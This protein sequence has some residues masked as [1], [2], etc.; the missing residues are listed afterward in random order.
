MRHSEE[1]RHR[2]RRCELLRAAGGYWHRRGL[3][4]GPGQVVA[5]P[6]APLLL[7]GLLAT[8][9]PA[10]GG[11][12]LTRPSAPWHEHPVRLLGRT[13]YRIPAPADCGGVPDPFVLLE[14][15]R[16]AR[17]AGDAPRIVLVSVADDPTGTAAAPELLREVCE[18]AWD[19][20]LLVV[21][22]ESGRDA[23]HDPHGTVTVSPAEIVGA[24]RAEHI[25]SVV[26][27]TGLTG[28]TGSAALAGAGGT[29]T[30]YGAPAAALARFPDTSR[31]HTLA[32]EVR[33]VLT[34]LHA[35]L[36]ATAAR[37]ATD[38]LGES[39]E[40]RERRAAD[41]RMQGALATAL[42]D[43]VVAAGGLCLPPQAG[44]SVYADLEPLRRPLAAHGIEDAAELA[45]ELTRRIGPGAVS[46]AHF[47]DAPRLLRVR[48]STL[49]LTGAD[50][51]RA[52]DP[53]RAPH[54]R[55]ALDTLRSVLAD[56]TT[57]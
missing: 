29:P 13:P 17:S 15:V 40:A 46:G 8:A 54:V 32:R 45:A 49:L 53:L 44:R 48:L 20:G 24:E 47:G 7:L 27:L 57:G 10:G 36:P 14:T 6:S 1:D 19:E 11:V 43:A 55:H 2:E 9:D 16:R 39:A 3:H 56:L 33:G 22:D 18:A 26:V 23:P 31:G 42:H 35:H 25:D 21:S 50:L 12:L 38:A 28:L 34:A 4:T 5:A 30:G 52:P 41:A 51:P 37:A